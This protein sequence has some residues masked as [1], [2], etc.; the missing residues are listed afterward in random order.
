E[1][2]SAGL[3]ATEILEERRERKPREEEHPR[4]QGE[5]D[6]HAGDGEQR[7]DWPWSERPAAADERAAERRGDHRCTEHRRRSGGGRPL[8]AN[9]HAPKCRTANRDGSRRPITLPLGS[10]ARAELVLIR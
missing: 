5:Q 1:H 8:H 3:V 6:D 10:F 2:M 4:F 9:P 7:E